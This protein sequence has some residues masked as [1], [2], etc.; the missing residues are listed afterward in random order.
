MPNSLPNPNLAALSAVIIIAALTIYLLIVGEAIFVP[1][2]LAIFIAYLIIALA[3]ALEIPRLWGRHLHPGLAMTAA[4]IIFML[5][6]AVLVQL[7]AG[8]IRAVVDAAPQ[9][10]TRLEGVL[11][12][13][14][15]VLAATF[16]QR[17]PITLAK[18]LNQ[19]DLQT[20]FERIAS[21]FRSIAGNTFQILIYVAFL[22]LEVRTF[23]RKLAS[24]F[25]DNHRERAIRAT[26]HQIGR[27]IET[28][29]WIKTAVSLMAG[30][31]SYAV[32]ASIGVDFAPFWALLL[33]ILNFIPYL[34]P[35]IGV[36]FPTLLALLQFGSLATFLLVF[37]VLAGVQALIGNVIEPRLTG[38][39]L[40]ISPLVMMVGLSVWGSIWGITGMILSVP[41]MVMAMI[42]LAQFPRTRALAILMSESGDIH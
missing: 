38:K 30:L 41:I 16:H 22:L 7:V 28:Y 15:R 6:I 39:S 26:L 33:F 25:P 1:L 37:A 21:A 35:V 40:N 11:T 13:T 14:N 20:I 29:V 23:D 32:L 3:H 9:Y 17:A 5:V 34:G 12:D 4:I 36:L 18:V 8:N 31:L 10:Q 24:M 19:I 2:V 27:K 42:V